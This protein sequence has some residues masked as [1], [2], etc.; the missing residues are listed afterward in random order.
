MKRTLTRKDKP[1]VFLNDWIVHNR[2]QENRLGD[3]KKSDIAIAN[4]VL[5]IAC[6][7]MAYT[8]SALFN[9][10]PNVFFS[11]LR[12]LS[13]YIIFHS[14]TCKF[15]NISN[16]NLWNRYL[17]ANRFVF[18][19]MDNARVSQEEETVESMSF[20]LLNVFFSRRVLILELSH[21]RGE[22]LSVVRFR[23]VFLSRSLPVSPSQP[24]VN[25]FDEK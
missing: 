2:V 23:E 19:P 13:F 3:K 6:V 16:N 4:N 9:T 5:L 11:T 21:H 22:S 18:L 15:N 12:Y 7:N 10:I 14:L 1:Y 20:P 25:C 24:I 8:F 17:K